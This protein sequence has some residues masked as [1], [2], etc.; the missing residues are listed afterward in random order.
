[1][2]EPTALTSESTVESGTRKLIDAPEHASDAAIQQLRNG[3][4]FLLQREI[5]KSALA[6]D[7]CNEAFRIV[8]ERLARHPLEDP[9]RLDAYL[10][11]TARKLLSAGRPMKFRPP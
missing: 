9:T 5:G 7:L 4:L 10:S 8:F 11:Q 3:V 1:M 2:V 6:E